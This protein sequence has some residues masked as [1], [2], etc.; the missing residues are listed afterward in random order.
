MIQITTDRLSISPLTLEDTFFILELVNT[1]SW[2]HFIGDR[3]IHSIEDAKHYLTTG[4]LKS[5]QDVGFGLFRVALS[6]TNTPIGINGI[7]KRSELELPDLG[8]ALLPSFEGKGYAYES[9]QAIL[10]W[11]KIHTN[12][13][14]LLAITSVENSRSQKLLTKLGFEL[15]KK[16][17]EAGKPLLIFSISLL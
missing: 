1:K 17:D 2:I 12:L 14:D 9:A 5:Y 7:L 6:E 13:T 10:E 15:S 4:P 3:N 16:K 8:F 11:A